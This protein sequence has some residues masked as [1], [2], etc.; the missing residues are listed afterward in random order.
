MTT[1]EAALIV[2]DLDG[3]LLDTL[4]DLAAATNWA[5]RKHGLSERSVRE[6]R[7]F[8][9]NGTRRLMERA[10]AAAQRDEAREVDVSLDAL[11]QD[12]TAY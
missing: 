1:N 2:F 5:L 9:G 12:F 10:L 3:T 8:V 6:V 4:A 7:S 11:F